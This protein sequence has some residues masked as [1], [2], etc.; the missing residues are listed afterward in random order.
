MTHR[1]LRLPI[2]LAALAMV[3]AACGTGTGGGYTATTDTDT[4]SKPTMNV[5]EGEP[6]TEL[7]VEDIV[8][9]DGDEVE[10][11]MLITAHYVGISW[12]TGEEFDASWER[13]EPIPLVIGQGQVIPGWDEGLLGM[14]VGGRRSLIIPPDM[15]YGEQGAPPVIAA[16]E[17]LVFVVDLVEAEQPPPPP[18]GPE[19]PQPEPGEAPDDEPV[20]Q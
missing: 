7:V 5:P 20:Q 16:N 2:L 10:V 15:A 11:G 18:A 9:G 19:Q 1:F 12:S 17:T 14:R 6:P 4:S 8:E 13:G 3:A